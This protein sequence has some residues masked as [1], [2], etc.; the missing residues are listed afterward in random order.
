MSIYYVVLMLSQLL[1][2]AW[3]QELRKSAHILV[4]ICENAADAVGGMLHV[5]CDR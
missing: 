4:A 1:P 5:G 3:R 2:P